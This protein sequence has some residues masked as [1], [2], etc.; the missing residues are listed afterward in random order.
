MKWTPLPR[1]W[2]LV[3]LP[4]SR[5]A[6][7]SKWVFKLKVDGRYR[8]RL[9]AKGFTQIPGLDFD[10]TFSPVARF[11]SLQLLLALA[12]LEDWHIHQMDV[13]SAFLNGELDKEIYM[14][15]PQGFIT[16]GKETQVCRLKKA[17]YGLK[18]ASGTWNLQLHGVLTGFSY[19]WMHADAGIYVCHQQEGDGPL[20]VI[21]YVDD[22]TILGKSLQA[23]QRL[24]SD[25]SACY[26]MSDLGE[27]ESYLGVRITHDRTL[28]RL[29][30]DQLGYLHDVL[31]RFGMAD[32]NPHSTPVMATYILS[33]YLDLFGFI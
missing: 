25:L 20:F 29:E 5:R 3:D 7:K 19:K 33:F 18:Q 27:I 11:E 16:S 24:K 21:I 8:A 14:E 26:E 28:K 9:V 4:P 30:I 12:A 31:E 22:I 10:E 15:Q 2:E 1:T 32:A 6:V 13:K 17:I 23:V